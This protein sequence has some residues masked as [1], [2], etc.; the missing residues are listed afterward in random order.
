MKSWNTVHLTT[1]D[2]TA[3]CFLRPWFRR[4]RSEGH[5]V[6][7]I[8]TVEKFG[9][10]LEAVTDELINIS[11]PRRIEPGADAR[12]LLA[13]TARLRALRPDFVHTHTSKA[14]L[15]GRLAT[16]LSGRPTRLLHTIHE[17]PQNSARSAVMKN[18]YWLAEKM[19]ALLADHLVTVSEVN[20]KQILQERI[21][22]PG[23]LTV[24]PNG[25]DLANYTIKSE[26]SALRAAWD[27]P[28]D[29]YILGT[30][31]R[32]ET[33]KGHTYLLEA[34]PEL[35]K[36]IPNL[37]WVCTSGT[38]A[39]REPLQEQARRLGVTHRVRWL[40]WVEDLPSAMA[41]FDL[42]VLPTLYEGQG[43][44]LLE[45][46]AMKKAIVCSRVGGTQ[47]VLLDGQTG[48]FV[49]PR[50]PRALVEAIVA[51]H[52]HPERARRFGEAGR[53]RVE[54]HFQARASDDKMMEVYRSLGPVAK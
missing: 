41:A 45:A 39:L 46:M 33:A 10:E 25:I 1:L 21:C 40:G 35:L 36:R 19:A 3:Y 47:D 31:A 54:E 52:S 49:P 11:I 9:P 37:Y 2:L 18:F 13:L 23:K 16:R 29:A 15:L 53:A 34:L 30:S 48:L 6:T 8:T 38:G 51:L 12:A 22:A 14:G 32:L 43:V 7:L 50:D 26:P 20:A 5:R 27:I 28:A 42:F 24:V 17:L 44:V 4:L